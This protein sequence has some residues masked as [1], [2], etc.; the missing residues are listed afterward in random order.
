[1]VFLGLDV[2]WVYILELVLVSFYLESYLNDLSILSIAVY[3]NL[4]SIQAYHIILFNVYTT[5]LVQ[6][7]C[8]YYNY[9]LVKNT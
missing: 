4:W 2:L 1:M 3:F 5:C 6:Y 9:G 7:L 8:I